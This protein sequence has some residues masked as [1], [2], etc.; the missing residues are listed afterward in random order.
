MEYRKQSRLMIGLSVV[1]KFALLE[2]L[3]KLVALNKFTERLSR[4]VF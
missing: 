2:I 4:E 1:T 3:Y